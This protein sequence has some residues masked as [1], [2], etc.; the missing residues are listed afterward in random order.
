[1]ANETRKMLFNSLHY[2]VLIFTML[3][4]LLQKMEELVKLEQLSLISKVCTELENHL[5]ISD[6]DLGNC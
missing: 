1:M 6:K 4:I 3:T 2:I 5:N